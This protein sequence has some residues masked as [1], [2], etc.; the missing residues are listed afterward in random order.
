MSDGSRAAAVILAAGNSKRLGRPKA[1]LDFHGK[2]ALELLVNSL[3]NSNIIEIHAV[4]GLDG[5]VST[6][7]ARLGAVVHRNADPDA[8]RTQSLQIALREMGE[9]KGFLLAPVDCPTVVSTSILRILQ[10]SNAYKIVRPCFGGRGGHP[11]W[12][13]AGV[14]PAILALPPA[15]AL[16]EIVHLY[17]NERFDLPVDDPEVLTNIDTE[18]D[19]KNALQQF[20]ARMIKNRES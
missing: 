13:A 1:L 2:T 18:E 10:F 9:A 5:A 15:A 6:E 11:V 19:Y 4:C 8:G 20:A 16:R 14:V 7:A 17:K 3:K 12:F